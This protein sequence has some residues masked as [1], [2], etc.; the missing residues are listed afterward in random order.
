MESGGWTNAFFITLGWPQA[1]DS[2]G[3]DDK[4]VI[5][6]NFK[7]GTVVRLQQI[8]RLDRSVAEWRDLRFSFRNR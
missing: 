6:R 1:H 7:A 8:C 5:P 2:S 3:R 4:V